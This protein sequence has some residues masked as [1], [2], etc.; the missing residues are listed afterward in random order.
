VSFVCSVIVILSFGMLNV[1]IL[2]V[3]T[4]PIV[5]RVIRLNAVMVSGRGATFIRSH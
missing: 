1:V 5:P 3:D 4:K 2:S